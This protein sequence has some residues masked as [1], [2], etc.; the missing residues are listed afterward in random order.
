MVIMDVQR[1]IPS[2]PE[3]YRNQSIFITG[4][5]GFM[6]KVLVEKLLRS[7][8]D[9]EKIYILL[10]EKRGR[11]IQ[12]RFNAM[13][14][15]PLFDRV[16]K[17]KPGICEE[18]LVIINGNVKELN[19]GLSDEDKQLLEEKVSI[20]FHAAASVRFDDPLKDAVLLN[21]RGTRELMKMALN[22][23]KLK[24]LLHV[25]TTYCNTDKKDV[26]EIVYPPHADWKKTIEIAENYN[27]EVL[28]MLTLS[29]INP[30]PNTYTFAKSLAEHVVNDMSKG[31]IPAVIFRPSIVISSAHEPVKG[32]IDNFNGPIGLLAACAKG[33][34]RTTCSDRNIISD[35][36]PV[37]IAIKAMVAAAWKKGTE[38]EDKQKEITVINS[39]NIHNSTI[40]AMTLDDVTQTGKNLA[41]ET[42]LNNMLWVPDG[43][44][45]KCRVYNFIRVITLHIIPAIFI[46]MLLRL[47]GHNFSLLK[48]QRKIYVANMA[49]HYFI[50]NQWHFRNNN[51]MDL[52]SKILD[53]DLKDWDYDFTTENLQKYMFYCLIGVKQFLLKED[54]STLPT[55]RIHFR[56]MMWLDRFVRVAF[57]GFIIYL[58]FHFGVSELLINVLRTF[59]NYFTNIT[60]I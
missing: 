7:C 14:N 25:S 2:I 42:P 19:L 57:T 41:H 15:I 33:I 12:T 18:K 11:D 28:Q 46:D 44:I 10:R 22:M 50:T 34:L 21:T 32:W 54:L 53:C 9:L 48:I 16:K 17:E 31:V 4:A 26:H 59:G 20:I 38:S 55:A 37:D 6:G 40:K 47:A 8:P 29:Y 1:A 24:V 5:N 23:K 51:F 30:L 45:T 3:F 27:D 60:D 58:Y 49:L 13:V 36:I 52:Q 56:R 35:F 43:T 39:S